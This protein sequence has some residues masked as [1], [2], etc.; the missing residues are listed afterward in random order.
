MEIHSKRY[1]YTGV[2][3]IHTGQRIDGLRAAKQDPLEIKEVR[4]YSSNIVLW[5]ES[6]QNFTRVIGMIC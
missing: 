2:Y 6:E 5:E 1:F 3:L 4:K